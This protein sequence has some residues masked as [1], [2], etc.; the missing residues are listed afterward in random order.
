MN[1][2]SL[3]AFS[4]G[5]RKV[6]LPFELSISGVGYLCTKVLRLLPGRRLVVLAQ[7][8]EQLRYVIKLFVKTHK[9]HREFKRELSGHRLACKAGICVP[10]IVQ[11]SEKSSDYYSVVYEYIE[12]S[13]T[14]STDNISHQI[15]DVVEF[16]ANMHQ[17]GV[18]QDDIHLDNLL[19]RNGELVLID[20]GSVRTDR[21][22]QPLKKQTSIKNLAKFMAQFTVK[23]RQSVISTVDRYYQ[24]RQ[25]QFNAAEQ[26]TLSSSIEQAWQQR[27]K[28]YLN[29]SFRDCSM[30]HYHHDFHW[31]YAFRREFWDS[32]QVADIADIEQ[33]FNK[34]KRLKAG[35]SATV[36][37]TELAGRQ[38]VI[39]RYNIK[40]F[41]H[42]LRRLFRQ[43]RA[44]KSWRN[45]NLLEFTGIPTVKPLGFIEKRWGWFRGA[46]YFL[47]EYQAAEELLDVYQRRQPETEES[48]KIQSI[49]RLL[50]TCKIGHGDMKAQNLLL[51]EEGE[52]LLIDLD[53]MVEYRSERLSEKAHNLDKKRF[54]R[55]WAD[56]SLY[57]YFST[58]LK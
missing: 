48:L 16:I 14:I 22:G 13:Q 58:L 21:P 17:Q 34:A 27:K 26:V 43:S 39:K 52:V 1:N 33:L 55:N 18:Y 19:T 35:N 41:S 11:K 8:A 28:E 40:S 23:Q 20:L 47:T 57:Q 4:E 5:K 37:Q 42:A 2:D 46:A 3:T 31:Q 25:W 49:F 10:Q 51:T 50:Q 12:H 38:V 54:L 24:K 36:I 30:T 15:A 53:S 44:A 7:N 45:A 6:D 29:K 9:G 56:G 32:W